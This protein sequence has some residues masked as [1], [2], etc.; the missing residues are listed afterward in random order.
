MN[1]SE[2]IFFLG[3]IFSGKLPSLVYE[4]IGFSG[5]GQATCLA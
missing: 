4:E 5:L 2:R 3:E 1:Y